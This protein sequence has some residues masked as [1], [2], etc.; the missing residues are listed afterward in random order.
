M[1]CL[2]QQVGS[3]IR[4]LKADFRPGLLSVCTFSVNMAEA[5]PRLLSLVRGSIM[6]EWQPS[7]VLIFSGAWPSQTI[8]S[9]R[10]WMPCASTLQQDEWGYGIDEDGD[11]VPVA[12]DSRLFH[13]QSCQTKL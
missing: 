3:G 11:E 2:L 8:D 6:R 7:G 1:F 13:G 5:W 4:F 12:D 9:T 10:C